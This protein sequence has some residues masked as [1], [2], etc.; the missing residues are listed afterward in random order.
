MTF[1]I[2][3][4]KK[5][6]DKFT[7]TMTNDEVLPTFL[8]I[9]GQPHY[10]N[11][12]SNILSFFFDSN[13]SHQFKD[14]LLKSL[15]DSIDESLSSKY[16]LK[17][18]NVI[19]EYRADDNK[20]IDL[21]IECED[22]VV[23]IENKIYHWLAND[24][25]LYEKTIEKNY[26]DKVKVYI[27]LSLYEQK[28]RTSSFKNITYKEFFNCLTKSLGRYCLNANNHYIL[29]LMDFIRS[30]EN[31]THMESINKEFFEFF[32]SNKAIIDQIAE[33]KDK[34]YN[35][36]KK[37]VGKVMSLMPPTEGNR[38]LWLYQ[39]VDI[40]NDF[41][42][43]KTVVALDVVFDLECVRG[44]LW[45]RKSEGKNALEILNGLTVIKENPSCKLGKDRD[46]YV[47]FD[48]KIN[49]ND[50]VPEDFAERIN[51]I[52]EKIKY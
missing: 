17:T 40:V 2:E 1:L 51:K 39:K 14:L 19:R 52:I 46:S 25:D 5:V 30:I 37:T 41:T 11:V 7:S 43:D 20:R 48:E 45:V 42:F 29:F 18:L 23:V 12:C 4:Y 50:I 26:R 6:V 49:F 22:I 8:E 34:L 9:C 47:I 35:S 33:E 28:I 44:V 10:E 27:V 15:L 3:D 13:Q 21:I 31:L 24:L 16:N 38:T 36:L 32:I